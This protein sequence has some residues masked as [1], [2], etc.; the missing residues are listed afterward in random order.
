MESGCQD[1]HEFLSDVQKFC[2][3]LHSANTDLDLLRAFRYLLSEDLKDV[4][5]D[6][7]FNKVLNELVWFRKMTIQRKFPDVITGS[8]VLGRKK[9]IK[10]KVTTVKEESIKDELYCQWKHKAKKKKFNDS[11]D[12]PHT[13]K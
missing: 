13:N 9:E 7:A 6:V 1:L 3:E 2:Y 11:L 5:F 4:D 8:G 12:L 10:R